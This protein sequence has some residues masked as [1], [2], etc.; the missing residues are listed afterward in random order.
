MYC[1]IQRIW[2]AVGLSTSG[3]LVLVSGVGCLPV[4]GLFDP[5]P[6]SSLYLSIVTDSYLNAGETVSAAAVVSGATGTVTYQWSITSPG[7]L[8]GRADDLVVSFTAPTAGSAVLLVTATDSGTGTSVTT[9]QAIEFQSAVPSGPL[10]IDA[11]PDQTVAVGYTVLLLGTVSG[12]SGQ[13][14][15][16]WRQVSGPAQTIVPEYAIGTLAITVVGTT[17]GTAVFKLIVSDY[18]GE[19]VI[20]SVNVT[21]TN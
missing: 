2:S 13:Y 8:V 9:A 5:A 1:S 20:D 3:I 15:V 16:N 18:F 14:Q 4:A 10:T 21:V 11:G 6:P 12:G 17:P 7:V 19:A